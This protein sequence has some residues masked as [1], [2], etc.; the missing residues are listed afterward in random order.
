MPS[1]GSVFFACRS[2]LPLWIARGLASKICGVG[3]L[4]NCLCLLS[5]A[6]LALLLILAVG[7]AEGME[8]RW[9]FR[10]LP[11]SS[12]KQGKRSGRLPRTHDVVF[13]SD[14][15]DS[16]YPLLAGPE[17]WPCSASR[18]GFISH[19]AV[20]EGFFF[21]LSSSV[22]RITATRRAVPYSRGFPLSCLANPPPAVA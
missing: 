16:V 17:G 9:Q 19:V 4:A 21:C 7:A 22:L 12:R 6:A 5:R 3:P 2:V 8:T 13:L 11:N 10:P 1:T 18:P 15:P 20:T 14:V